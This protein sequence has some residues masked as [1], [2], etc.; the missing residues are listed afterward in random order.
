MWMGP[1]VPLRVVWL[2]TLAQPYTDFRQV[3][4]PA[5]LRVDDD[6]KKWLKMALELSHLRG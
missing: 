2:Q 3:S 6:V 4:V 5:V 1:Q